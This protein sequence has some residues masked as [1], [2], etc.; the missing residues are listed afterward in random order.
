MIEA[1]LALQSTV[2][3]KQPCTLIV[4]DEL[5]QFLGEDPQRTLQVQNVVE[6][7]SSRFGSRLLFVA[8]G[9]A[10]LQATPQLQKLQGR[11][12]VRVSLS[13]TDV[14]QVVR[15]VV[16]RKKP[17]KIPMLNAVLE[18][19]SGEIDRHLQGTN[20]APN[21]ADQPDLVPDYP[22][23]PVRRRFW[24]RTLRAIDSAGAAGQLRTQLRI[25]HEAARAV[26]REAAG[27]GC[28]GRH[29]LRP[30]EARHVAEQRT[31]A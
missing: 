12:T 16:L 4:L 24:E 6:A 31:A 2:Q 17:D 5:Q 11:F 21:G 3:G 15:E 9:Q 19:A 25:V 30:A 14:E 26:A 10:A 7:C 1:V 28:A 29:D 13:D 18:A 22:L 8:T 27:H 23:L 20:I